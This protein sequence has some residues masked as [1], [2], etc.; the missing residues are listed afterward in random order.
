MSHWRSQELGRRYGCIY[1]RTKY[2]EQ[3]RLESQLAER[4]INV[5]GET[6]ERLEVASGKLPTFSIGKHHNLKTIEKCS[7]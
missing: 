5:N 4:H 2:Y 1:F 7:L 6:V 3:A